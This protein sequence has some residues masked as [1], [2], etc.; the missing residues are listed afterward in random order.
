[1]IKKILF[2][3]F[4][5][6]VQFSNAQ[7]IQA[8][9]NTKVSIITVGTADEAHTFYGHTALRFKD[10]KVGYDFVFNFGYFDFNTDNFI[11]KFVKGDLQYYVAT[12]SYENFEYGYKAENRS[13]YEQELRLNTLQKQE[14]F[15][16]INKT[17][18]ADE[19][20]YTY[21][22]IDRNCTTM[23]IDKINEVL[24]KKIIQFQEAQKTTYRDVLFPYTNSHFYQQLGINLIFGTK[25]DQTTSTLF[26]PLDLMRELDQ[27]N[28]NGKPIVSKKTT[29]FEAKKNPV[30]SYVD[31]IYSLIIVLFLI[32][33]IN[34]KWLTNTYFFFIGCIGVFLCLVGLYSLHEEVL[35]NYNA[36]L[37]NPLY[38]LLLFFLYRKNFKISKGIVIFLLICLGVY[39]LLILDKVYFWSVL[40]IIITNVIL[41]NRT[42]KIFNYYDFKKA[43]FFISIFKRF[44]N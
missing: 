22:F 35:W 24:G 17:L 3:F 31:S 44:K 28:L 1:M 36:L 30:K 33:F 20:F 11:L 41:L 26:L 10:I 8:T 23:V 37:L 4:F 42:S 14:L 16:L 39:V 12:N 34:K 27:T 13:I 15:T 18:Y 19:R 6:I 29:I 38:L 2:L 5:I 43:L 9:E 21:K 40:P 32:T 7:A 25:V